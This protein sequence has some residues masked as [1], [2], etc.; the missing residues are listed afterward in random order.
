MADISS[1]NPVG[2]RLWTLSGADISSDNPVD[3][4]L[5]TVS[6]DGSHEPLGP[7]GIGA[8]LSDVVST[9]LLWCSPGLSIIT[10]YA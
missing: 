6:G 9:Y 2:A 8:K 10:A 1:D 3:A 4:R 5:W 7:G